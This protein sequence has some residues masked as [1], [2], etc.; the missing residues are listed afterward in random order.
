M[1]PILTWF[2]GTDRPSRSVYEMSLIR[3][4]DRTRI[5]LRGF[6]RFCALPSGRQHPP[7]A[8]AA[9]GGRMAREV[10]APL[11]GSV[12]SSRHRR[13][14][15]VERRVHTRGPVPG[16]A[17]D[18]GPAERED[19]GGAPQVRHE[20]A[21]L[22]PH[23]GGV[24]RSASGPSTRSPAGKW[25]NFAF[26][27]LRPEHQDHQGLR[28]G[29]PRGPAGQH[30]RRVHPRHPGPR[31]R[32]RASTPSGGPRSP[33]SCSSCCCGPRR[34]WATTPATTRAASG[35]PAA[36]RSTPSRTSAATTTSRRSSSTAR[37]R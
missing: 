10:Q 2:S 23:G 35:A 31:A 4:N 17:E 3:G 20:P 37:R 30:A 16:A 24:L 34:A 7:G 6:V 25:G 27:G 15:G 22:R 12:R 29:E 21:G 33:G 8:V 1:T 28:P 5:V 32:L 11:P 19:R 9:R 13:P 26:D 18:H 14:A 36:A